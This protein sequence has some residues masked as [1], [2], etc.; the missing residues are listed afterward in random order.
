[1]LMFKTQFPI[2]ASTCM[3]EFV[4]CCRTWIVKSPHTKLNIE[5]PNGA[6]EGKFGDD[7]EAATFGF[8]ESETI[9][10]GGVRYEKTDVDEVRW[11]TDVIGHKT[12]KSFWVSVQLNVDSELPV[13]R[14]EQGK[15]PY[16][17]KLLMEKFA[18]GYDGDLPVTDDPIF[19]SSADTD[20]AEK[21]ICASTGSVM[22]SVYISRDQTDA[23]ILEP[24][25]LAK[26]LSGMAHVVVEPSRKFSSQIMRQVYGENVYGGAVA[27][28]WPD[29]VGKWIYLPS[30]WSSPGALQ[31][32]IAKK[33]RISL[34]YQR[35]RRECTWSYLQEITSRQKLEVLRASGSH[36]IDEYIGHFDKEISAKDE[37]IQRLEAE[38]IRARYSKR[39][40]RAS[41]GDEERLINL[42]TSESDLYQGEQVGLIIESLKS[43]A[44]S[45]E[46]HSRRRNILDAL[47]VSN[48]NPGDREEILE[49]LKELLRQYT[50]MTASVRTEFTDLG[51]TIYEEGK[52]YKLLFQDDARYPFVLPKTGS[53]WR[54][55]LNAFSD[56]KKRLF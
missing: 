13:E 17:V 52:H 56:L 19:L 40:I 24:N 33:I 54:G 23:L 47:V 4:D 6:R 5:I 25:L 20:L 45:A 29:G 31:A 26:W 55:G 38:L 35:L 46:L 18:G 15:R 3:P 21:I 27:I 49:R 12:G 10:S 28:Y 9:S 37:E 14:L 22:P 48:D 32:A 2:T 11:V 43:A 42:E 41:P 7:N 16:I 39:E 44:V 30:R 51:F 34:L 1:M 50:S 53:D 36:N 8:F